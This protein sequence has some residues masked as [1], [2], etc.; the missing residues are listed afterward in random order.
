VIARRVA[1]AIAVST[2][3]S[4]SLGAVPLVKSGKW[5]F[6]VTSHINGKALHQTHE[7]CA[8]PNIEFRTW[9]IGGSFGYGAGC[10]WPQAKQTGSTFQT[11]EICR[12]SI[13]AH[14]RVQITILSDNAYTIDTLEAVGGALDTTRIVAKRLGAC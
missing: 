3:L 11:T 8:D 5:Q 9:L 14:K 13:K 2:M 4:T 6:D 1:F 7:L 12:G 10:T